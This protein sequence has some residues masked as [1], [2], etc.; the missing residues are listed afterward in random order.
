MNMIVNLMISAK[1][2]IP[3]LQ[4]MRAYFYKCCDVLNIVRDVTNKFLSLDSND[5]A[6]VF[7][8]PK[9]RN[10]STSIENFNF[11]RICCQNL[12]F[13]GVVFVQV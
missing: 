10:S 13:W 7:I 2:A 9:S 4:K 3:G 6:D 5:I 1:L 11:V 12:T 8:W